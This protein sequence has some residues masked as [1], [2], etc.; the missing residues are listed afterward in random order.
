MRPRSAMSVSK[1]R[2]MPGGA[3]SSHSSPAG[4]MLMGEKRW[5]RPSSVRLARSLSRSG[6]MPPKTLMESTLTSRGA[7]DAVDDEIAAVL[8][9]RARTGGRSR[10]HSG[11]CCSASRTVR[12]GPGWRRNPGA[13][14]FRRFFRWW[15]RQAGG[16]GLAACPFRQRLV[17]RPWQWL[18]LCSG[19]RVGVLPVEPAQAAM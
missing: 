16:G 15:R 11:P 13:T 2:S 9:P 4:R 17:L 5:N 18:R 1:C 19:A 12:R 7:L 6:W 14:G 10:G 3:A 8:V